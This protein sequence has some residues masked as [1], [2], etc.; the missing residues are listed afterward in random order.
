MEE[1]VLRPLELAR[2]PVL[3]R[4]LWPRRLEVVERPSGSISANCSASHCFARYPAPERCALS[5]VV[6][7]RERRRREWAGAA[8]GVNETFSSDIVEF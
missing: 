3:E 6:P 2:H 4:D 1:G 8:S 7:P 5:A